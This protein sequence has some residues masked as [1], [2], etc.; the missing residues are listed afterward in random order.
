LAAFHCRLK[1]LRRNDC[2]D[3][4]PNGR[5]VRSRERTP[6]GKSAKLCLRE[7]PKS[8]ESLQSVSSITPTSRPSIR[9]K[10]PIAAPRLTN[11]HAKSEQLAMLLTSFVFIFVVSLCL[12]FSCFGLL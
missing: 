2:S 11:A 1:A 5:S 3:S 4:L 7:P 12:S 9:G 8:K 10:S 6:K